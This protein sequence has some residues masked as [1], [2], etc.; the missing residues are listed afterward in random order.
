MTASS[1]LLICLNPPIVVTPWLDVPMVVHKCWS[2][3]R[4][5]HRQTGQLS[6]SLPSSFFDA[7]KLL[8]S[9]PPFSRCG[10]GILR[11]PEWLPGMESLIA[12][13]TATQTAPTTPVAVETWTTENTCS[14][15]NPTSVI[16]SVLTM[17]ARGCCPFGNPN[18]CT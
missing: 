7:K 14:L 18:R 1:F 9:N 12:S 2:F 8:P 16:L 4:S 6:N 17:L 15:A 10:D 3:T 13:K 5:S 11:Q